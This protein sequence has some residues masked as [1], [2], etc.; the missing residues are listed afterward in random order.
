MQSVSSNS[1]IATFQLLS[2]AYLNLGRSQNGVSGNG[3]TLYH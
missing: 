3:L 1:F 2:A